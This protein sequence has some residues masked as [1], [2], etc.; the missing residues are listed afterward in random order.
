M[1]VQAVEHDRLAALF[2]LR[3]AIDKQKAFLRRDI[4]AEVKDQGA[5]VQIGMRVRM[6]ESSSGAFSRMQR[7]CSRAASAEAR[8]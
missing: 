2:L 4:E 3:L 6:R 1:L 7:P 8:S 5:L